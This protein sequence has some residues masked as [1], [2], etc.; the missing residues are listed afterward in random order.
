M[1]SRVLKYTTAI[2]LAFALAL[3]CAGCS[4]RDNVPAQNSSADLAVSLTPPE[5][6]ENSYYDNNYYSIDWDDNII[7]GFFERYLH[8]E[9]KEC[10]ADMRATHYQR[11]Q[12]WLAEVEHA[13]DLL[14]DSVNPYMPQD[15]QDEMLDKIN[16]AHDSFLAY[17]QPAAELEIAACFNFFSLHKNEDFDDPWDAGVG[18]SYGDAINVVLGNMYRDEAIRLYEAMSYLYNFEKPSDCL[19]FYEGYWKSVLYEQCTHKTE[20]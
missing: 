9:T 20:D 18:N 12:A 15:K 6:G 14:R 16:K 10:E 1:K 3:N 17:A 2:L 7:D 19:V 13:Y 11:S 8:E 5:D 4:A